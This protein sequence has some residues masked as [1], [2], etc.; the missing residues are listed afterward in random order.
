MTLVV[1]LL[2]MATLAVGGLYS[3][4]SALMGERLARN[5]LDIAVARQSAEA[6]LRDAEKDLSLAGG[7][8][9]SNAVCDRGAARPVL[10]SLARFTSSCQEG[11]CQPLSD[12]DRLAAN[13]QTAAATSTGTGVAGTT[14]AWWPTSKGGRWN[15]TA[16]TKPAASTGSANCGSFTG[17]V[18]L[19]TFTG[20]DAMVGV[21]QQPEYLIEAIRSVSDGYVFRITA[22]GFGMRTGAEVVVQ[23]YFKVVEL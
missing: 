16:S 11:Q 21:S 3:A 18:P 7:A 2:L 6:A 23:S 14:E 13:Y 15:D 20:A 22:R 1:V 5:Q 12:A 10:Q 17:A 19:G 4:R 8:T 9:P